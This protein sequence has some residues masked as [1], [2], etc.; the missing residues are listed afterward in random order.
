M[1]GLH[2]PSPAGTAP[3]PAGDVRLLRRLQLLEGPTGVEPSGPGGVAAVV[4]VETT[5]LS[6]ED[7]RVIELA[8][9][10]IA[11]DGE[12]RITR[13]GGSRSWV[14]DPGRP[15]EE[16]I[17]R[18]TGLTDDML[19]GRSIDDEAAATLLSGATIVIAHNASFD[20]PR[21]ERRLPAV[22]GLA[23]ACSCAEVDWRGHGFDGRSLGH[24]LMQ[25]GFFAQAHRAA[26]DVDALIGLL[27][28]RL[29]AGGTVLGELVDRSF[30]DGWI[31]RAEG[32]SFDRRIP[33]KARGY[34]WNG[35]RRVWWRELADEARDAEEWWL[36]ENVYG[37]AARARSLGPSWQRV[38]NRAR[39][40]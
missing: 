37:S 31:V 26:D 8:V 9:R 23:W 24:L 7:D 33:L 39:W 12:G 19:H 3:L 27:G 25:V 6:L 30:R 32:A 28:H 21:V 38:D 13:I 35:E 20:R 36:A 5:G 15:L 11:Y 18:L 22:R 4:D 34:R 17:V 40:S 14:E 2:A 29:D 16:D 10:R 1:T